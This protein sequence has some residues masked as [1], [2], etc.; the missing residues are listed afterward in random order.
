MLHS[1]AMAIINIVSLALGEHLNFIADC[2]GM[3]VEA[4]A[5]KHERLMR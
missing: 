1:R 3:R 4:D 5:R 2:Y